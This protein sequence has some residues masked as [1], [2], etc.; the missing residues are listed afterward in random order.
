MSGKFVTRVLAGWCAVGLIALAGCGGEEPSRTLELD[1]GN[2]EAAAPEA[3]EE[4]TQESTDEV[5]GEPREGELTR[6]ASVASTPQ[7]KE[8]AEAWFTYLEEFV[9]VVDGV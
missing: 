9:R 5:L 4:S 6:G 7:E 8:V 1:G 3:T 2:T